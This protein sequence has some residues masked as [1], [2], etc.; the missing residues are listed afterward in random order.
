MLL[1]LPQDLLDTGCIQGKVKFGVMLYGS[2]S[3]GYMYELSNGSSSSSSD[4]LAIRA[5]RDCLAAAA[6][7]IAYRLQHVLKYPGLVRC[8]LHRY[9]CTFWP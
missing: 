9:S 7:A 5:C 8:V 4:S 2:V 3:A 6:A 1:L